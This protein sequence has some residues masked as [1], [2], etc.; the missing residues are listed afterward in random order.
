MDKTPGLFDAA[1]PADPS[2]YKPSETALLLLDWHSMFVEKAAG[3][4]ARAVLEATAG[5]RS[6]AK[7]NDV[8]IIHALIDCSQEPF[9]TCKGTER[10]MSTLASMKQ[11]GGA[12]EPSLLLATDNDAALTAP[13]G[14]VTFM[15]TPGHVSALRSPGLLDHLASSGVKSLLLTGVS[16]SGCVARI[17]FAATDAEFVVTVISDACAEA[18]HAV[19]DI[20]IEKVLPSRVF[21]ATAADIQRI[22]T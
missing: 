14:E 5:L 6:W 16:T 4:G 7:K 22:L 13:G 8:Q 19:H 9:P 1:S 18:D 12:D 20:M 21:I 15:R 10:L 2:Y 3:A 17:A 11:S